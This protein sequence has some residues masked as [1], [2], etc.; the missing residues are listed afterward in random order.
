VVRIGD[1]AM[2][3]Y[4][5][6]DLW[7]IGTFLWIICGVLACRIA[8]ASMQGK[9]PNVARENYYEDMGDAVLIGLFG[10]I[11]LVVAVLKSGFVKHGM[12]F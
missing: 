6:D 12:N 2:S 5:A 11:G 4:L 7:I 1:D 10:P 8:F 9:F 3:E